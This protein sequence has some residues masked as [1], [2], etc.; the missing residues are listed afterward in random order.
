MVPPNPA[1]IEQTLN[2]VVRNHN[3]PAAA[4]C[5]PCRLWTGSA[6][7]V[8]GG[9]VASHARKMTS[10]GNAVTVGIT[11][12]AVSAAGLARLLDLPP[13]RRN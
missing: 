4:D 6:L 7:V 8:I 11:G 10:R 12:A 3:S 5:L 2:P 1:Q 13:F 9:W